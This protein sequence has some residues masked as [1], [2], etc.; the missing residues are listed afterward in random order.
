MTQLWRTPRRGTLRSRLTI[1]LLVALLTALVAAGALAQ[2]KSALI[3]KLEGPELI[4]DPGKF[5]KTFKEAPQL[6]E[7]VRPGRLPPVAE[8]IGQDPL[9]IKPLQSIGKYGGTWRGG[10]TGPADFW[11]GFR[12]CSGP[13][14]LM[15]WD[16]T[17]DKAMPNLARGLEMQDGGRT[18]LLHLEAPGEVRHGLVARV[19][20][21]HQV[22]RPRAAPE[23]VPEVG[24]PREAAAPRA[25]VPTDLV[26]RLDDQRVL[27]DALGHRRELA[28][29]DQL[30]QL[31]GLPER[32][33]KLRR[34]RDDL[35]G[36]HPPAYGL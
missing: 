18:W 8:R 31:R 33:G 6:A 24:R 1:A 19:V 26:E 3:G 22:V 13:D 9:V 23:A 14:H 34:G 29:L 15:F 5:P 11:N 20:P 7:R 17:G 25:A 28:R 16:Y 4:T 10:F 27:P 30:R 2:S 32:H 36:L 35:A 12:C 21:E